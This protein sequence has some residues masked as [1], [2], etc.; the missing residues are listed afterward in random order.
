MK[1]LRSDYLAL[2]GAQLTLEENQESWDLAKKV[3]TSVGNLQ[4]GVERDREVLHEASP[5]HKMQS[6]VWGR[7]KGVVAYEKLHHA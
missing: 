2:E 5:C 7:P 1:A 4:V 3:E 6:R